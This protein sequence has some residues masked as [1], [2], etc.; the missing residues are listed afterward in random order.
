M[1]KRRNEKWPRYAA[2]AILCLVAVIIVLTF[3]HY[4]I[5]WDEELQS[6]YGLAV[7]D[8]YASAFKDQRYAEIFNLY[9]YGGMFDGLASLID[10]FTPFIVYETRHLVNAFFGLLGLWGI[11]RLGR[12]IGGGIVGLLSLIF[13]VLTPVYYGHM[14]NN[15]KDIPFAAGVIWSI[16]FMARTLSE[17]PNPSASL[18]AKVG[19]IFGLT[20][21]ERVGGIMLLPFWLVPMGLHAIEPLW[22]H[23]DMPT[24]RHACATAF[25]YGW[26]VVL[27]AA[28]LAYLVMLICWPWA[29]QHP[30]SNPLRALSEFSNFPQDV[31]VLLDGTT[32]RSTELPWTYVPLYISIQ[33]PELILLLAGVGL[34]LMPWMI[35]RM[36][37]AQQ[38][39]LLLILLMAVV[40][41]LYAVIRHPALYDTARHFLFVEP[42]ICVVAALAARHIYLWCMGAVQLPTERRVIAGML[43]L[44]LVVFAGVQIQIMRQLH[45]YEYIFIN[46][47]AGGVQGAYGRYELDYWGTSFKAATEQLQAYVAK[48]GGVP[49]GKIYKIAI[50]GPWDAA[51]I[52]MPPDYEPVVANE[53]AEFFLA[54]TRWECQNMRPGKEIIRIKRLG[55]PLAVVKDLRGGFEHYE[56]NEHEKKNP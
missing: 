17:L 4:G 37:L 23:R 36:S 29:Q 6:Q 25:R 20:L 32:Y 3:R 53:P 28:A 35:R 51:M 49:S 24:F 13:L 27:P 11:W 14:F 45:P 56:G 54:T 10:R 52:Y 22:K 34:L 15:P 31:E 48:E 12:F 42:L 1:L 26:R 7:V 47:F 55:A 44:T 38:Q 5:T 21:G 9:L 2:Q 46:Q 19:I 39:G 43:W 18:I 8:Y 40:P 41:V 16:Y 30:I 50:C 33:T